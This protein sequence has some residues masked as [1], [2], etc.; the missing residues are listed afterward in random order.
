MV[1]ALH[2]LGRKE[3]SAAL[4]QELHALDEQEEDAW[5]LGFARLYAWIGEPD[6]AFKYLEMIAEER[7]RRLLDP[8]DVPIYAKLHDDPR[9][10]PLLRSAGVAPE[11]FAAIHFNP[12]L[13]N[14]MP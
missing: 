13:P 8:D 14:D 3:E 9:W 12:R 6:Q 4:L 10:L 7:P 5:S 2:D 1:M 11:Q